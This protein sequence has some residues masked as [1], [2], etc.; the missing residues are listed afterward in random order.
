MAD[1]SKT[2]R[3]FI[4]IATGAVAVGGAVA[5]TRPLL[6]QMGP[7]ADIVAKAGMEID[8]SLLQEGEQMIVPWRNKPIFIRYRTPAEI[9]AA[10]ADDTADMIDPETDRSRLKPKPSGEF[11]PRYLVMIGI[12]SHFGCVPTSEIGRFN[13]WRCVCHGADFDTSGRVRSGPAPRN[14]AIPPY[15]WVS[16]RAIKLAPEES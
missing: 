5:L 16:E 13:A 1:T 3:D 4:F 8:L 10:Q 9:A 12:C 7:A 15:T 6:G 2:R 14:M 11:D